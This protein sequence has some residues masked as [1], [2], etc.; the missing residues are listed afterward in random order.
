M[1]GLSP[2]ITIAI[3]NYWL[4]GRSQ[5]TVRDCI[6]KC[7]VWP[8]PQKSL[9]TRLR[10]HVVSASTQAQC[11]SSNSYNNF[12]TVCSANRHDNCALER[13]LSIQVDTHA[14][15]LKTT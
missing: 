6:E 12:D 4:G 1:V 14:C 8:L 3:L 5:F 13:L 2:Y 11:F 10:E 7:I 15:L 9:G